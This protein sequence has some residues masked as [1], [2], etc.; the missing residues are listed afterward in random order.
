MDRKPLWVLAIGY[1]LG[2]VFA[3]TFV[4][5]MCSGDAPWRTNGSIVRQKL[6][7]TESRGDHTQINGVRTVAASCR[8]N[9]V[10]PH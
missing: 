5:R 8:W 6:S 3:A 4:R 10:R 2:V 9:G 1:G 7:E